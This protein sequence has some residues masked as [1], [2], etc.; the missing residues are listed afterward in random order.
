[1]R[2]LRLFLIL[3]P[4]ISSAT[5]IDRIAVIVGNGVVKDS[6]IDRDIRVTAFLNGEPLDFSASARKKS[7]AHLI[8]QIFIRREI[9]IGDYPTA[10]LQETDQQLAALKKQRFASNSAYEQALQRY[11]VNNLDLRFRFQWQL[12][13]LHFIDLRFE[14][15][16]LV[17]DEEIGAYYKAHQSQLQ[18]EHPGKSSLDDVT[19]EIHDS[20]TADK[21]NKLFFAWL[22]EQ[23][24]NSKVKFLE[25]NLA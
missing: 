24:E 8:D 9:Q 16:V 7:A 3:F 22:D 4:F 11:G 19:N 20:I 18:R 17:T 13:V 21:V 25:G 10:T 12:T 15:A 14:P 6:D 2:H 23:R 1:M 5:V